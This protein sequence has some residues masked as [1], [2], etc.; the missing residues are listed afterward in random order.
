MYAFPVLALRSLITTCHRGLA[1]SVPIL[2]AT[3]HGVITGGL[4][5][6]LERLCPSAEIKISGP[7]AV[8]GQTR[9]RVGV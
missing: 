4:Q 5:E 9:S 7:G 1:M 6:V 2:R 3:V 8:T